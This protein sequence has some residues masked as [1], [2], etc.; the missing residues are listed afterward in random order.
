MA[1]IGHKRPAPCW[2]HDVRSLGNEI[3]IA[4]QAMP[5][6][7]PH[8]PRAGRDGRVG[9]S[10]LGPWLADRATLPVGSLFRVIA[11]PTRGHAWSAGAARLQL[12]RLA[13]EPGARRRFPP[14][15]L[16]HAHAAEVARSALERI[17]MAVRS[18][19][20][21]VFPNTERQRPFGSVTWSRL[22]VGRS[23]PSDREARLGP[24]DRE[25]ARR[26]PILE[27]APSDQLAG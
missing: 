15:Q 27:V 21:K 19:E 10:A 16:S 20:Q 2:A 18:C 4:T 1:G 13:P 8:L 22:Q 12:H 23:A 11:G 5:S 6:V 25:R 17:P 3:G 14:Q 7:A 9:W 24:H 26:D